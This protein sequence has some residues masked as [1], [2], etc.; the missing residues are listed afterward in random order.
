MEAA[1]ADPL[2]AH[3]LP[4]CVYQTLVPQRELEALRSRSEAGTCG[5][6]LAGMLAAMREALE[7][8]AA[9]G[10]CE[11]AAQPG[12][13]LVPATPPAVTGSADEDVEESRLVELNEQVH[14]VTSDVG[15]EGEEVAAGDDLAEV[16]EAVRI[17][18]ASCS[19][20]GSGSLSGSSFAS[21][22]DLPVEQVEQQ[23]HAWAAA[24]W[25]ATRNGALA[26]PLFAHWSSYYAL[27]RRTP[28]VTTLA[29]W[30]AK[31]WE[32]RRR[33]AVAGTASG[34]AA[35]EALPS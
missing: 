34:S 21:V 18:L 7:A 5:R 9:A 27:N 23:R 11:V 25:T 24:G 28:E 13:G 30:V 10:N 2:A 15:S 22:G 33:R 12:I 6:S 29:P 17:E 35:D 3:W 32:R 1:A 19:R 8:E 14:G 20:L 26:P 16:A 4:V 31:L